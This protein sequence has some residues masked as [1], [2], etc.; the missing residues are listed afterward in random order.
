[1]RIE[2]WRNPGEVEPSWK[3]RCRPEDANQAEH[4]VECTLLIQKP[5]ENYLTMCF[6]FFFFEWLVVLPKSNCYK[7]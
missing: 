1:M 7:K 5:E 6:F 3:G 4:I 2:E